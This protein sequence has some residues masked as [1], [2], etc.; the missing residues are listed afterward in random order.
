MGLE[1]VR[2]TTKTSIKIVGPGPRFE[3]G[4]PKCAAGVPTAQSLYDY[5]AIL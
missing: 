3:P 2:N 5:V 1:V 4:T